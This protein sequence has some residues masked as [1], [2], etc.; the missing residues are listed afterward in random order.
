MVDDYT[1]IPLLQILNPYGVNDAMLISLL[2]QILN[3]YGVND[4]ML[5]S[6]LQILT[7]TGLII[8]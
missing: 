3:P 5:I 8:L 6:L 1:L 7:P 4:A 2:L